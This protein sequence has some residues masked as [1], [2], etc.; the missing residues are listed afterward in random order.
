M[1][2]A[3]RSD[4]FRLVPLLIDVVTQVARSIMRMGNFSDVLG[5]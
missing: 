5:G 4:E 2:K 3:K 1:G